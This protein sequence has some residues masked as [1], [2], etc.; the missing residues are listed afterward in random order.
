MGGLE[1][2]S[3]LQLAASS[4]GGLNSLP[5]RHLGLDIMAHARADILKCGPQGVCLSDWSPRAHSPSFYLLCWSCSCFTEDLLWYC[6]RAFRR[7]L[8][9]HHWIYWA[10]IMRCQV[11]FHG[12][13]CHMRGWLAGHVSTMR[14]AYR[15]LNLSGSWIRLKLFESYLSKTPCK[16]SSLHKL[17][18]TSQCFIVQ[19]SLLLEWL[20]VERKIRWTHQA[21]WLPDSGPLCHSSLSL[22][23]V[24][25]EIP[26]GATDRVKLGTKL[27]E[28][29]LCQ[30]KESSVVPVLVISATL[31]TEADG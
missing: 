8:T 12:R 17:F 9:D 10:P 14:M 29:S 27:N 13:E 7:S 21:V 20:V 26:H 4:E 3:S 30:K 5:L 1:L 31:D 18:V 11:I 19:F 22:I 16:L 2:D 24:I 23:I 25:W 15:R 28:Y 6:T